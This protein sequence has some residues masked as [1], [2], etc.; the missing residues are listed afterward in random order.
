LT[1]QYGIICLITT[2]REWEVAVA[3][4]NRA[5]GLIVIGIEELFK[6]LS[7]HMKKQIDREQLYNLKLI[8]IYGEIEYFT[9]A[10]FDR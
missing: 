9:N 7:I 1:C 6:L 5:G 10:A 2:L 3:F 8:K 4:P